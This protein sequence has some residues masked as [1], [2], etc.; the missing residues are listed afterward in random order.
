[1]PFSP[2]SHLGLVHA[3]SAV[4]T[5]ARQARS[6]SIKTAEGDSVSILNDDSSMFAYRTPT[7]LRS[8]ASSISN[9]SVCSTRGHRL[10]SMPDMTPDHSPLCTSLARSPAA[11]PTSQLQLPSLSALIQ[12]VSMTSY[13]DKQAAPPMSLAHS[14]SQAYAVGQMNSD[15]GSMPLPAC[16]HVVPRTQNKRKYICVYMGCGKA[17]TT[18]GHLSRHHRI[19]TG[20]KNYPCLHPGCDSRFSRQDNMMQHYRT[21]L[22]PRSRRNRAAC[23]MADNADYAPA[24][25]DS[26]RNTPASSTASDCNSRPAS[27]ISAFSPY[28]RIYRPHSPQPRLHWPFY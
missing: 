5:P 21:H 28:R 9:G 26:I 2:P 20:E 7:S 13:H 3:D 22:S 18:S 15:G 11:T 8:T 27:R 24:A 17:F 25:A 1:M 4:S 10:F 6:L 23:N 19:H 12:A 14:Y 16:T